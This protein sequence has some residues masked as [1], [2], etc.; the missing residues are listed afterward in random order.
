VTLI[1]GNGATSIHD[2]ELA[3]IG[4]TSENVPAGLDKRPVRHGVRVCLHQYGAIGR[5]PAEARL[6]RALGR[7]ICDEKFRRQVLALVAKEGS[8]AS[9]SILKSAVLAACYRRRFHS[10][11]TSA[12]ART[13]ST[14]I[15]VSTARPKAAAPAGTSSSTPRKSRSSRG[16][17]GPEHRQRRHG[18]GGASQSRLHAA[19]WAACRGASSRRISTSASTNPGR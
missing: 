8:I 19:N 3:L 9:F 1:A 13:S 4:Q 11:F 6:W 16:R 15:R 18:A 5:Q 14:S 7:M 2:F 10:P 12:W 17:R